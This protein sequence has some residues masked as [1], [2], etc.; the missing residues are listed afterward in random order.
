MNRVVI[1]AAALLLVAGCA[2]PAIKT[3][4]TNSSTSTTD[5]SLQFRAPIDFG[6]KKGPV[7]FGTNC[8]D[9]VQDGDCGLGEPEVEV[10]SKGTVYVAAVCC[11]TNS[12]PVYVSR[13]GGASFTPLATPTGVR[14]AQGI[15][16]DFAI[17]GKGRVYFTDIDFA[18]SFQVSVWDKDGAFQRYTKWPAPPL[19]DRD[20][21]R[22]EGDGVV[23]YAYNTATATN[24]YKS[25]DAGMTWSPIY[26]HQ[27][28]FGLGM[29]VL[30]PKAGQ[31]WLLGPGTSDHTDDGGLTWKVEATTAPPGNH[32]VVG[33][34]DDAGNLYAGSDASNQIT[35]ARRSPDGHWTPPVN[36]TAP[37]R[38]KMPWMASGSDGSVAIAWYGTNASAPDHWYLHAAVSRDHGATW[39]TVIADPQPVFVGDLQRDLLD[40]FQLEAG[41]DGALHIAYSSLPQGEGNE[42][43]LRY[44]RS[45]PDGR[46]AA[47][48]YRNGP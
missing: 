25:T 43:H 44:V 46:F 34:F 2:T 16:G 26:I 38:G 33:A 18:A 39:A 30:G 45:E 29:A 17:D 15:E 9:S 5:A 8:M 32:F 3:G 23:Y 4:T 13:D 24:V 48:N 21:V 28:G 36:I 20:W 27:A 40:F 7:A 35:V 12:P 1:A 11:L 41:P 47:A 19:V 14:E 31:Y 22:A 37:E 6:T 42:E 10:D